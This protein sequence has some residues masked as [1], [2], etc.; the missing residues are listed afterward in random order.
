MQLHL[1]VIY[2]NLKNYSVYWIRWPWIPP[3][4]GPV[5]TG[6]F[7]KT[8]TVKWPSLN[9]SH[10]HFGRE[11]T[12]LWD[13]KAWTSL[14]SITELV[15]VVFTS[16]VVLADPMPFCP[17][18]PWGGRMTLCT[19]LFTNHNGARYAMFFR[20]HW[21]SPLESHEEWN[22]AWTREEAVTEGPVS[23][24]HSL[25]DRNHHRKRFEEAALNKQLRGRLHGGSLKTF[26]MI[27]HLKP[28]ERILRNGQICQTQ[29]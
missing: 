21:P 14:S 19:M 16:R 7:L 28:W 9:N 20:P 10:C 3:L 11:A 6:K 18:A 22:E 1:I 13:P 5:A 8:F 24:F 4:A 26:L 23:V 2:W 15:L 17:Q 25:S 12:S 29:Q 27:K